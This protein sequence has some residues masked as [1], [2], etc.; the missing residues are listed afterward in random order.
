MKVIEERMAL[1]LSYNPAGSRRSRRRVRSL[2]AVLPQRGARGASG[3]GPRTARVPQLAWEC[4]A[5]RHFVLKVY[6]KIRQIKNN[7]KKTPNFK[8]GNFP[9]SEQRIYI[10]LN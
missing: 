9:V 4:S 10:P 2:A 3:A 5:G 7:L 8:N 1:G 6:F